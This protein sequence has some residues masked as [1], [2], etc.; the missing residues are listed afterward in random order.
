MGGDKGKVTMGGEGGTVVILDAPCTLWPL[1]SP[2][3]NSY[4]ALNIFAR[5]SA[6]SLDILLMEWI[7]PPKKFLPGGFGQGCEGNLP[8]WPPLNVWEY[9]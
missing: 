9:D 7:S 2:G 5:N 6:K 8:L 3:S 4:A 1:S